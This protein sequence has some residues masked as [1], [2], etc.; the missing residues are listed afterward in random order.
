MCWYTI[1]RG[2]GARVW[3]GEVGRENESNLVLALPRNRNA[4]KISIEHCMIRELHGSA[5]GAIT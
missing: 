1:L 4:D 5:I 3:K 2:E